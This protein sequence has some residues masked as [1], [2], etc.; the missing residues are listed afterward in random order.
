MHIPFIKAVWTDG[1]V[2]LA[3]SATLNELIIPEA[4]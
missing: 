3:V 4:G 2:L 1:K